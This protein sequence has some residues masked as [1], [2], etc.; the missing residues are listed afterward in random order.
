MN[1]EASVSETEKVS[2]HT[3]M[4]LVS[5]VVPVF[6]GAPFLKESLDS[7]LAQHY[8]R[9]EILVMDDASTDATPE[10]LAAYRGAVRVIRQTTNRGIYGN[11]NDGIALCRGEFIAVF[12]ADD[13]YAP[14]IIEREVDF[15]QRFPQAGAVFCLDIFVDP[16]GRETGRLTLP[17]ELRGER[18]LLYPGIL[19]A[20][21][22]YKNRFLVCPTAMV[23]ASVYREVGSYRDDEFRNSADMEMW[24]R[25]VRRHPIGILEEYLLRYR[26]GHNSSHERYH[27]LRTDPE[28]FFRIIDLDLAEGGRRFATPANLRAYEAHRMEDLLMC[29]IRAYVLN[30]GAEARSALGAVTLRRLFEA[31]PGR[32]GRLF[33]LLALLQWLVRS[34]RLPIVIRFLRRR[35]GRRLATPLSFGCGNAPGGALS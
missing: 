5:I 28:R 11:A 20:L 6:N 34:P 23:R 9:L 3:S 25:I 15:L 26:H 21:L 27:R 12:H 17:P 18:P 1:S 7:L 32:W 13:I 31:P 4:P 30:R 24:L 16:Y 14:N 19:N 29:G 10:I 8:P 35:V 2:C 33:A 22:K